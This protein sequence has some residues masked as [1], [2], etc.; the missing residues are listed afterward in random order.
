MS[1]VNFVVWGAIGA[2]VG[3]IIGIL[4]QNNSTQ[5]YVMDIVAGLIGGLIGGFALRVLNIIGDADLTGVVHMPSVLIAVFG[6]IVLA[7][8]FE[9]IRHQSR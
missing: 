1:P 3:L 8:V 4:T 5:A 9:L 7:G 6:A 2:T